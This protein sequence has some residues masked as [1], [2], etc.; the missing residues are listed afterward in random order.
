[1]HRQRYIFFIDMS[2]QRILI[3]DDEQDLCDILRFNLETAGYEVAVAY[4]AEEA[5]KLNLISFHLLLLDVMMPGMSGFELATKLKT[6]SRTASIPIIFLT[7]KDAEEDT[8][9]GFRIGADDYVAKPFSVREVLARVKAVLG[10]SSQI[11]NELTYRTLTMN[12]TS[13]QLTIDAETIALTKTEFELLALLLTHHGQVFSRQ[14]LIKRVWPSDVIVTDRT[15]DV[16]IARL[17]KKLGE[18]A[19]CI[20]NK[21]GYGYYFES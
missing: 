13:K 21:L 9:Y 14:E 16:N 6:D 15:V 3:V 5:L 10:R 4:T 20:G 12:L 11:N 18:Y 1:M 8:L 17:R 2:K 19:L 7:A